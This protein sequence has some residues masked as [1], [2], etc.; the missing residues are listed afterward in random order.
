MADFDN[1]DDAAVAALWQF[2]H[3]PREHVGVL[4]GDDFKS[5]PFSGGRESTTRGSFTIPQ[6]SLRALAHNHPPSSQREKFSD[7]DKHMAKHRNVPSYIAAGDK[8]FRYDPSTG[9]TEEVLALFP[10]EHIPKR[11]GIKDV[12]ADELAARK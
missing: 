11:I 4:Y 3:A 12:I 10:M 5:S 2:R 6:G 7:D 1:M 8:T 9:K